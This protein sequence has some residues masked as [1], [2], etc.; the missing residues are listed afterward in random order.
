MDFVGL[1]FGARREERHRSEAMKLRTIEAVSYGDSFL[2][3]ANSNFYWQR[4]QF[5]F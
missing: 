3:Q 1:F 4:F 2:A 5:K